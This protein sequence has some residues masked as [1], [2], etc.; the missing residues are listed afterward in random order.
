MTAYTYFMQNISS[1]E[2]QKKT[3]YVVLKPTTYRTKE[4]N[5]RNNTQQALFTYVFP[6]NPSNAREIAEKIIPL[7]MNDSIREEIFINSIR[8]PRY[9]FKT[10]KG[11]ILQIIY[12]ME[13]QL[14]QIIYTMLNPP[15][16]NSTEYVGTTLQ[17]FRK[18][19]NTSEKNL[20]TEIITTT[21]R[22]ENN[23]VVVSISQA[24]NGIP[25]EKT[26][27]RM[28]IDRNTN[29]VKRLIIYPIYKLSNSLPP[30]ALNKTNATISIERIIVCRD[31]PFYLAK[32]NN[33]SEAWINIINMNITS[34]KPLC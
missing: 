22:L 13:G 31:T 5:L 9:Y 30:V 27:I 26:G 29:T 19:I 33:Q 25:L 15:K 21:N 7:M 20:S 14:Y 17:V 10:T 1:V 8:C 4:G 32:L 24:V 2:T 18:L 34:T 12:C 3:N 6:T 23:L 16:L 11:N 28:T